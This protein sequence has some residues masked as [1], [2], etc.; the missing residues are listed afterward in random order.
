M[1]RIFIRT[2]GP[3]LVVAGPILACLTIGSVRHLLLRHPGGPHLQRLSLQ[4]LPWAILLAFCLVPSVSRTVFS[5][6]ECESIEVDAAQGQVIKFLRDDLSVVCST[7]SEHQI[8]TY[9]GFGLVVLWPIGMPLLYFV[10][11][12]VCRKAIQAGMP[13]HLARATSFLWR[14]YRIE[15][16]WWE[17]VEMF[18]KVLLCGLLLVSVPPPLELLRLLVALFISIIF[19]AMTLVLRPFKHVD[20]NALAVCSHLGTIVMYLVRTALSGQTPCPCQPA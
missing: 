14:E 11:V 9:V 18:R 19:M 3:L 5:V 16:F 15:L 1:A 8:A 13:T 10:L 6:W 17:P 12:Y 7:S 4:G 2:I 20:N